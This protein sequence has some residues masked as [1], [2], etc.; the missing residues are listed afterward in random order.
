MNSKRIRDVHPKKACCL[1]PKVV[2]DGFGCAMYLVFICA[3]KPK[4]ALS[5][6]LVVLVSESIGITLV[7][8]A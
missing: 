6:Q 3:L 8:A 5:Y 1:M 2:F 7:N 4:K